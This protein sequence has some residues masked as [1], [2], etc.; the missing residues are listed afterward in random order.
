LGPREQLVRKAI[1][2][3]R[4]LPERLVRRVLLALMV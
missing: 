2:A 3:A 1:R 4:E